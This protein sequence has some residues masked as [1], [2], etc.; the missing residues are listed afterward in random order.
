MSI[1]SIFETQ[2]TLPESRQ[3]FLS[4]FGES[5]NENFIWVNQ[6]STTWL[7]LLKF[8]KCGNNSKEIAD[9]F[10]GKFNLIRGT[11]AEKLICSHFIFNDFKKI[12]LG[13]LVENTKKGSKGCAPDLLI[14][15]AL[16]KE[17]IPVEIK[18]LKSNIKNADYYDCF[19]LAQK[20]C[21]SVKIILNTFVDSIVKRKIVILSWFS[22]S[23]LEYEINLMEF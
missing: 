20:Q 13:L 5:H 4:L 16:T 19:I 7:E 23:E 6:R 11:I 9:G 2:S 10:A 18:C 14:Y 1:N 3:E 17:V 21:E 8:Y 22:D 12:E 15:N